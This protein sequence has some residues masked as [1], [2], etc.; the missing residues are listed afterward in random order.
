MNS[1]LYLEDYKQFKKLLIKKYGSQTEE[2]T[3]WL[4]DLYKDDRSDWGTAISIG[5][6]MLLNGWENSDTF[7]ALAMKGDNFEI[8]CVIEYESKSLKPLTDKAKEKEQLEAF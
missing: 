6:L 3:R 4:N 5:H 7:I 1:N 8:N 2:K